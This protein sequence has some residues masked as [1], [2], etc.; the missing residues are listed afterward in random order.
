MNFLDRNDVM[1]NGLA[2]FSGILFA[3]VLFAA[4]AVEAAEIPHDAG[5]QVALQG[6]ND[7]LLDIDKVGGIKEVKRD[8]EPEG[9]DES[10]KAHNALFAEDQYPSAATCRTCHPKQYNE[11]SVSQHSYSQLSPAYLTLSNKILSL[12]NGTNGDFCF[13]CHSPVGANLGEDPRMSNLDR[14]PT[15]REGIT[16]TVCHRINKR[17]NKVSG[18]L[19]L[20]EG[21]LLKPVYGP[22]GNTEMERV[23]N[24]RD[25]YRVVTKEGEAGRQ[26]HT[27]SK[28]FGHL[29]SS[30]FCGSCHDVTL[31]NG[32]RL[33]EAFSEYRMSPAA[34]RGETC[35]DCHMGKIQGKSAG[36]DTGPAA[37]V[38]G[39]PTKPRRLSSHTF[40]GP[41]YSLIHP[42]IFPHNTDAQE[43]ATLR[44]WLVF[45]HEAGWGTDEFEDKVKEGAKFPKRW[46]A[47]DDRYDAREILETQFE[48]LKWAE[49]KRYEVLRN[50]YL[51]QDVKTESANSADGIRFK[52]KVANGTDGHNVPTGFTGER[53]VFLHVQVRDRD[54]KIVFKSG[55]RDPNFDLLDGHSFYVHAGKM[56]KDPYLFSL[57]SRFVTQNGRGGE[58]EHIIPIP[59]PVISLPRVLP[60]TQSLIFTGEPAAARNHKIGIEPLGHRWA[61]YFVDPEKLS[62]KGPYTAKIMLKSQPIP[63][64]IVVEI[65]DKGFDY[66]YSAAELGEKLIA[67]VMTLWTKEVTFNV[68][69]PKNAMLKTK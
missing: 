40:A 26:I 32:F 62:G 8:A 56:K 48:R 3:I 58:I 23:L 10:K 34:A 55:H 14:H 66:G 12:S 59:Y 46:Q 60:S 54:G 21:S 52:V 35:Q 27:E 17:Y 61:E 30:T 51:L 29:T 38:G 6:G 42:G 39:V 4:P 11:W 41:D 37:V 7:L 69:N 31:F 13:R 24:N 18:R 28:E 15:S 36:Y 33:E 5:K 2:F 43:M 67:G 57:Q 9:E 22:L 44:E 45:D 47:V 20:E 63:A 50:G 53:V 68:D 65:Q 19:D 64:N 25:K 1:K 16:C 49:G